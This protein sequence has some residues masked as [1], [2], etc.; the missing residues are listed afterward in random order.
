MDKLAKCP[1]CGGEAL[2]FRGIG[3]MLVKCANA[4]CPLHDVDMGVAS[5]NTRPLEEELEQDKAELVEACNKMFKNKFIRAFYRGHKKMDMVF[6]E[7]VPGY[8]KDCESIT[9][10]FEAVIAALSKAEGK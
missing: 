6:A 8:K 2:L 7:E 3:C 1:F 10:A 9:K 5:W 4:G